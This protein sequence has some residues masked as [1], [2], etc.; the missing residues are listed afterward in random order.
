MVH[1][2]LWKDHQVRAAETRNGLLSDLV[3]PDRD[4][5]AAVQYDVESVAKCIWF[6]FGPLKNHTIDR[7]GCTVISAAF[8]PDLVAP[9]KT[10][11][12]TQNVETC[13]LAGQGGRVTGPESGGKRSGVR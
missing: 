3:P 2:K 11:L 8:Y 9:S 1:F 13:H 7:A 6:V 12:H 10:L 5:P 4:H